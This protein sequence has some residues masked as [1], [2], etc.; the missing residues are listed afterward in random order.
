MKLGDVGVG[1]RGGRRAERRVGAGHELV[2]FDSRKEAVE[3]FVARGAKAA[4]SVTALARAV[5]RLL[6]SRPSPD[7]A[8]R[9]AEEVAAA[10]GKVKTFVDLSATGPR[11]EALM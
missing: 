11:V 10:G 8:M 1:K 7:V 5:E 2:V 4:A 3:P 9:V 6:V